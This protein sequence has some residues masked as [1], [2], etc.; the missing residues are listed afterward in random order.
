MPMIATSDIESV[1]NGE[2]RLESTMVREAW[3]KYAEKRESETTYRRDE[4]GTPDNLSIDEFMFSE[5]FKQGV[6]HALSK[7]P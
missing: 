4:N 7:R 2:S 6:E 1:G 5:G 3:I